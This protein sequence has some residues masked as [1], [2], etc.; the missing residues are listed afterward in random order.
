MQ[1]ISTTTSGMFVT[2]CFYTFIIDTVSYHY[3][4]YLYYHSIHLR[5]YIFF[6]CPVT[7]NKYVIFIV[8]ILNCH[9]TLLIS[10]MLHLF[11]CGIFEYNLFAADKEIHNVRFFIITNKFRHQVPFTQTKQLLKYSALSGVC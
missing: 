11:I 10:K 4:Y 5:R 1:A 2:Y 9:G 6:W 3:C 7:Y 8:C